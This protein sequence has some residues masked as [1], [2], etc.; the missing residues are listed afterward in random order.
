[1]AN[2]AR[3]HVLRLILAAALY[4]ALGVTAL[5]GDQPLP[6][7]GTVTGF[8]VGL[9]QT[10][11]ESGAR[12]L[13]E[14]AQWFAKLEFATP[15]DKLRPGSNTLALQTTS[16]D[17]IPLG[18]RA[19]ALTDAAD[20]TIASA[21][22]PSHLSLQALGAATVASGDR[23]WS[24]GHAQSNLG[25]EIGDTAVDP[26]TYL[27]A[28]ITHGPA[29]GGALAEHSLGG[30][31]VELG[32]PMPAFPDTHITAARYWW[33]DRAFMPEVQGYRVGL[34]YDLNRHLQFEG[35]RSED[36]VHGVAG[37]FGLRYTLPLDTK[38]PA[39]VMLP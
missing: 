39:G 11:S 10:V 12:A 15:K 30:H 27:S 8:I 2:P 17:A 13:D 21:D 4:G 19:V 18:A 32:L 5:A 7:H 20:G 36:Q 31:D 22:R 23:G 38:R 3:L 14:A 25:A 33:G 1:M 29:I 24:F 26:T 35:G 28:N 16:H 37:F 9:R 34:S 6:P